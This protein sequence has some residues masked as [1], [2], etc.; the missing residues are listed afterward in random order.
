MD[1]SIKVFDITK[2]TSEGKALDASF[3]ADVDTDEKYTPDTK[4]VEDGQF[5]ESKFRSAPYFQIPVD[6]ITQLDTKF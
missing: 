2:F 1:G 5:C 3:E 6:G 4:V